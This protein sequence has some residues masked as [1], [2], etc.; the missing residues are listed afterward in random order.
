MQN[1]IRTGAGELVPDLVRVNNDPV[2]NNGGRV[3]LVGSGPGDP[4]LITVAGRKALAEADVVI[5]DR[6]GATTL[7]DDLAEGV[8]V[9]NVGKSPDN[10]P[11]P[12]HAI[13]ALLV[14]H[15][16]AGRR[17]VRFKGGD[18]Y[19]FGRGG[20]EMHACRAAG[21][22]VRVIPGVTSALSVPALAGIPLTQRGVATSVLISSG[23]NGLDAA[24]RGALLGGATVVLLMA[25]SGLEQI[26]ESA[27]AAGAAPDL[28][29]AIVER[30][31][32][33]S[34]RITYGA[35]GG[36]AALAA[37]RQVRPP[38]IVVIGQVA[39]EAFLDDEVCATAEPTP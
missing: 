36:I 20:E 39:A 4:E 28:P 3:V 34:E 12:Q 21:V 10:H 37:E 2:L 13:N 29:V 35:L 17:V 31:S 11:V 19:I 26:C 14:E 22:P 6:L 25:V 16:R 23:H 38:A 5:T 7:L 18:P 33:P 15:A 32:T 8:E 24:A 27:L 30:G 9:I 1:C